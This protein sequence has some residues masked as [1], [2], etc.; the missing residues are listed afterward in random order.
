MLGP[1][2]T[3]LVAG[4]QALVVAGLLLGFGYLIADALAGRRGFDEVDRWGLSLFGLAGFSVAMMLVHLATRGWLFAHPAA[5][6]GAIALTGGTLLV[7]R[8]ARSADRDGKHLWIA[9]GL[10]V[11]SV[12]V[13]GTPVARMMPLTATADTQLHNGW[14]EQLLAGDPM[15]EAVLT[16]DVPNYYPWMFHSLGAITSTLTPGGTPYHALAP[17]QLLQ[18]AGAVLALFALGRALSNRAMTG[19]S[20]ALLGAMSG[21][22][23]FLMLNGL[24]VVSDP[25]AEGG[26]AALRYQG[27]L[28]FSRSY[29]VG[30]HNLA[31]PFPRDLAFALLISFV[32][33]LTLRLRRP[34][35]WTDVAAG[36]CLGFVGLTGGETFIVGAVLALA[37]AISGGRGRLRA[38]AALLGPALT[39]YA[40]WFVPIVINY[41]K[42]GGFVSIT[43]IIAV[44]LP[45]TA[46][47]VSWGLATPLAVAALAHHRKR[48]VTDPALRLVMLFVLTSGVLLAVS[49]FIPGFLGDAFDTLGRK[50]RYWPIFYLAVSLLGA[51]GLTALLTRAR[52]H[53]RVTGVVTLIVAT[54]VAWASPVVASLALPTHIGRYPEIGAAMREESGSLLHELHE[55]GP[56]CIV[57]APQEIAREVFSYTGFR[58][59]LWTGNWFG[60]NRAR[61]RWANIYDYIRSEADR[62][63]DNR[64]LLSGETDPAII[65]T[66]AEE[67][68]LDLIV[69]PD[70]ERRGDAYRGREVTETAYGRSR[71][72]IVKLEECGS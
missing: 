32:L 38:V 15:F 28:L 55:L 3:E 72:A 41:G 2:E 8:V 71:Y 44:A 22:F 70:A 64:S 61:I 43:H 12:V 10:V 5:V 62:I 34:G 19:F 6:V 69:V 29:N 42:L 31:P 58:L 36:C 25:R 11:A 16:G 1:P 30:F 35:T 66:T 46:I 14:I 39:I 9:A 59:V 54:G 7:R 47:L 45:A 13:W 23:G 65:D 33:L 4:L 48:V 49:A 51:V 68:G 24:D 57:A 53:S 60:E 20:A 18:V 50:H 52:E 67:Y 56:G 37:V 17:L 26:E 40:L 21:G 27:D 63:A